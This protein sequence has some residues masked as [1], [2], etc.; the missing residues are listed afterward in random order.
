[1]AQVRPHRGAL[2][3]C[4]VFEKIL[5]TRQFVTEAIRWSSRRR[6]SAVHW[7]RTPVQVSR[8]KRTEMHWFYGLDTPWH[9]TP[10]RCAPARFAKQIECRCT[11]LDG[12]SGL[13]DHR[14]WIE[15]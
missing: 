8:P 9:R 7:H 13:L 4:L 6:S 10:G 5:A 15:T 12:H 1:M 14:K 2:R 3:P 11:P